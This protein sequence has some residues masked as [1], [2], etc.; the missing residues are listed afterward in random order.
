MEAQVR[1]IDPKEVTAAGDA[2]AIREAEE[3]Y[4][5]MVRARNGFYEDEPRRDTPEEFLE[6]FRRTAHWPRRSDG[7]RITRRSRSRTGRAAVAASIS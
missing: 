2:A 6:S 3:A 4:L 7:S 5:E 1:I